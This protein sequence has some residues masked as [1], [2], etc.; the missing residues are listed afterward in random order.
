MND[1]DAARVQDRGDPGD[2]GVR[3]ERIALIDQPRLGPEA[4]VDPIGEQQVRGHVV[5]DQADAED[6]DVAGGD[7]RDRRKQR[8]QRRGR[9]RR[10]RRRAVAR[11]DQG[12]G[13]DPGRDRES[14]DDRDR[15]TPAAPAGDDRGGGEQRGEPHRAREPGPLAP[16]AGSEQRLADGQR[17]ADDQRR[18]GDRREHGRV[19]RLAQRRR[20]GRG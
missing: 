13:D 5:V 3:P 4:L 17:A 20:P 16:P 14:E 10:P 12:T 8:R 6:A 11:H 9:E 15:G 2:E 1:V 18:R 19:R 7:E